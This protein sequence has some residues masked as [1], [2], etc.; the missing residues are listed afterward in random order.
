MAPMTRNRAGP[1]EAPSSL[2]VTYYAQRASAGLIVTEGTQISQEGQGYPGTP[3]IHS[4]EQIA[5]WTRVTDSVH[6]AGGRIFSS[7]GMSAASL[8]RRSS[9]AAPPRSRH[10]PRTRRD[11]PDRNGMRPFVVPRALETNEIANVVDDYR[12]GAANAKGAGF[13]GVELHGANGYLVDQ[14]LRDKTNRRTDSYGGSAMNRARFLIEA[15][16]AVVSEWSGDRLA[17]GLPRPIPSTTL[18]IAIPPQPFR[19]G[20]R[21]QTFRPRLSAHRRAAAERPSSRGRTAG[22]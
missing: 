12:R 20:Q 5:G 21:T 1:G 9:Q 13:D 3:G 10:L 19:R 17:C 14:F 16:E 6:A 18:P 7:S 15:T 4:P 2:A 22:Y 11:R 8:I